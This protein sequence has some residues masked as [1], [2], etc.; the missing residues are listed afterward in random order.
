MGLYGVSLC[1][2]HLVMPFVC[3]CRPPFR[4]RSIGTQLVT[5]C[6]MIRS[7]QKINK[8][9]SQE[10]RILIVS[11]DNKQCTFLPTI[12]YDY[13]HGERRYMSNPIILWYRLKRWAKLPQTA[14]TSIRATARVANET[15]TTTTTMVTTYNHHRHPSGEGKDRATRTTT[16]VVVELDLWLPLWFVSWPSTESSWQFRFCMAFVTRKI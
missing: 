9:Q 16:V 6:W 10:L 4:P 5:E 2:I 13:E 8:W 11:N 15:I 12:D 7:R 14:G 3:S 1:Y